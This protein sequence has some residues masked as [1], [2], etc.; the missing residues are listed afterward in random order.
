MSLDLGRIEFGQGG[1]EG[2]FTLTNQADFPVRIVSV[3]K[4]CA[5]NDVSLSSEVIPANGSIT[6]TSKIRASSLGDQRATFTLQTAPTGQSLT[7]QLNWRGGSALAISPQIL[8]FQDVEAGETVRGALKVSLA[9]GSL[10]DEWSPESLMEVTGLPRD[11]VFPVMHREPDGVRIDVSVTPHSG[12]R[13]GRGTV[14][15]KSAASA[16]AVNVPIDWTIFEPV[17][18]TPSAAYAGVLNPGDPWNVRFVIKVPTGRI[19]NVSDQRP[20]AEHENVIATTESDRVW[21]C[22]VTGTAPEDLGSFRVE[23]PVRIEMSER[24]VDRT[25]TIAGQVRTAISEAGAGTPHSL[26]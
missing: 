19:V 6:V 1:G 15:I 7:F 2:T 23:I 12:Q 10:P 11:Q 9:E 4:S 17:T 20:A 8:K 13:V 22:A 5:C 21:V 16:V 24:T 14:V 3:T 26:K 18:V 25:L